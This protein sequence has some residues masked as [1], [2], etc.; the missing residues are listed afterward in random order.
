MASSRNPHGLPKT[1]K[2]TYG[3]VKANIDEFV[4]NYCKVFKKICYEQFEDIDII[5]Q[6][7]KDPDMEFY[8]KKKIN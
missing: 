1:D 8:N 6:V 3:D 4:D 7:V 2:F 5:H